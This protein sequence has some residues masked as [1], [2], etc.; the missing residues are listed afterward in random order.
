MVFYSNV[1]GDD[2]DKLEDISD[3]S[4]DLLRSKL[5]QRVIWSKTKE[6]ALRLAL[7]ADSSTVF[8]EIACGEFSKLSGQAVL[9]KIS[10]SLPDHPPEAIDAPK[11]KTRQGVNYSAIY[12]YVDGSNLH[13]VAK[14]IERQLKTLL[15]KSGV[16]ARLVNEN[17]E[18]TPDLGPEDLPDWRLGLNLDRPDVT[19]QLL[20]LLL[21]SVGAIA[22]R[23]GREFVIG[24]YNNDSGVS[25]DLA[26][27]KDKRGAEAACTDVCRMLGID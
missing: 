12:I 11:P 18:R 1:T 10:D 8:L 14:R 21:P 6:G 23:T 19:R 26:F 13:G 16:N 24:Y 9:E 17:S 4:E 27:V 7:M 25:E 2:L 5:G 20:Q 22:S 3:E 15:S